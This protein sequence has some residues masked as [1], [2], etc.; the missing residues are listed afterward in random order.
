M[1]GLLDKNT[2]TNWCSTTLHSDAFFTLIDRYIHDSRTTHDAINKSSAPANWI[3]RTAWK[4]RK[5]NAPHFECKY[6][7]PDM[8]NRNSNIHWKVCECSRFVCGLCECDHYYYT[9]YYEYDYPL[10]SISF[11]LKNCRPL[12]S[13]RSSHSIQAAIP[14]MIVCSVL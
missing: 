9:I 6:A 5:W 13:T 2:H 3:A 8:L 1:T 7:S 11:K 4:N 14:P 12:C 10:R